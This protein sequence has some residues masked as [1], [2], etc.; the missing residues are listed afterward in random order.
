MQPIPEDILSQFN[1]VLEQKAFIFSLR[2][3][4]R[5]ETSQQYVQVCIEVR[6]ISILIT[7]LRVPPD[8]NPKD[9]FYNRRPASPGPAVSPA[10]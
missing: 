1:A 6:V 8:S 5:R 2:E 9:A 3:D 7:H 10:P 4:Y